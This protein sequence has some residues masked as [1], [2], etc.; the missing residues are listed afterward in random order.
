MD[1]EHGCGCDGDVERSQSHLDAD[2]WKAFNRLEVRERL[3]IRE[4]IGSAGS[5]GTKL[6]LNGQR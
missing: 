1:D 4:G 6:K 5:E 2:R 3:M